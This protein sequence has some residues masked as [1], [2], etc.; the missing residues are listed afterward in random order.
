[1]L[2]EFVLNERT[3]ELCKIIEIDVD[4]TTGCVKRKVRDRP[5]LSAAF[6]HTLAS[7]RKRRRRQSLKSFNSFS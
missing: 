3:L 6:P 4:L 7:K 5:R 2:T 1:V